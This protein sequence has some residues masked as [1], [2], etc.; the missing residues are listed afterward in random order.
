STCAPAASS[1]SSLAVRYSRC[2]PRTSLRSCR[3][4]GLSRVM[5]AYGILA[6]PC[7]VR[8]PQV[9]RPRPPLKTDPTRAASACP[10]EALAHELRCGEA[11]DEEDYGRPDD[12][13]G[14][15]QEH[16]DQHDQRVLEGLGHADA[17]DGAGDQEAEAVGRGD[18]AV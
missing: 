6:L 13:Q 8:A 3:L 14:E 7:G 2:G 1:L 18:Q 9:T 16:R 11:G 10:L 15:D 5:M 17:G 12:D 4:F